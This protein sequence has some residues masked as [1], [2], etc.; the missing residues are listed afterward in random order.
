MMNDDARQCKFSYFAD[1]RSTSVRMLH[2]FIVSTYDVEEGD[3]AQSRDT[4]AV[5][6]K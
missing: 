6:V 5:R 2:Q 3:S 1:L 4:T